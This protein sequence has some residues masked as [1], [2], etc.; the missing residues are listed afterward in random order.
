MTTTFQNIQDNLQSK[1]FELR[2]SAGLKVNLDHVLSI[3]SNADHIDESAA[4]AALLYYMEAGEIKVFIMDD[5]DPRDVTAE[6]IKNI[7]NA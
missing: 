7:K 4:L 2:S 1:R 5:G 6:N 3:T